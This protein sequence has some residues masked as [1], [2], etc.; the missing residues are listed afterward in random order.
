MTFVVNAIKQEN[1]NTT[2]YQ[3]LLDVPEESI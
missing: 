3:F 2:S 1:E